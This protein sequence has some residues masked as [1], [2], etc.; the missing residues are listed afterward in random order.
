MLKSKI[1]IISI[2]FVQVAFAQTIRFNKLYIDTIPTMRNVVISDSGYIML[3]GGGYAKLYIL[4]CMLDSLGNLTQKKYIAK[5][6]YNLYHGDANSL[7]KTNDNNYLLAGSQTNGI[8]H[9]GL[10]VKFNPHF[11]TIWS[12]RYFIDTTTSIFYNCVQ[13]SDTNYF[14][15]GVTNMDS[16]INVLLTNIDTSGNLLWYKQYGGAKT[17]YGFKITRTFDNGILIGGWSRSFY[18][19][20][21]DLYNGDW[22]L[23]KTDNLGIQQWQYH[24]GNPSLDDGGISDI[25]KTKDSCYLA[26]GRYNYLNTSP[27]TNYYRGRIIKFNT[28]MQV[29][30]DKQYLLEASSSNTNTVYELPDGNVLVLGSIYY[31]SSYFT[32]A[33]ITKINSDGEII[34]QRY[35]QS[36]P[37]MTNSHNYFA[38]IEC[39]SDNGFII[40]GVIYNYNLTPSQQMWAV[41]TDCKGYEHAPVATFNYMQNQKTITCF[42]TS[43]NVD[44]CFWDFGDSSPLQFTTSADTVLHTY[45]DTG[46]FIVQMVVYNGCTELDNDTVSQTV[47]I[48]GNNAEYQEW[49]NRTIQVYPNPAKESVTISL[50]EFEPAEIIIYNM[51]GVTL[52]SQQAH[53][54]KTVLNINSFERGV[55]TVKVQ[56]GKGLAVRK[57]VKE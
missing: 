57:L 15:I 35:F 25:I 5:D 41:K 12:K 49:L 20:L 24:Y 31:E 43:Q 19:S 18:P 44:S 17:D 37:D 38:D 54:K 34:W 40:S 28:S 7:I 29:V 32:K 48:A 2:L 46:T 22:Y 36:T 51:Q 33:V 21:S 16:D 56:T 55:Y 9:S 6:N 53:E 47:Y 52:F 10:L 13:F 26:T 42:N 45:S 27:T 11:D 39:T 8:E 50:L 14:V 23:I 1:L 30:W 3:G 4:T